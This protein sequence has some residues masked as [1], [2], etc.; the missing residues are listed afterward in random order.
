VSGDLPIDDIVDATVEPTQIASKK[1]K[2]DLDE[3]T[4]VTKAG[5]RHR[6][7]LEPGPPFSGFWN[8]LKTVARA[9]VRP[10]R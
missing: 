1:T 3:L 8:V 2:A 4:I 10:H 9:A 7:S 5:S 6:I